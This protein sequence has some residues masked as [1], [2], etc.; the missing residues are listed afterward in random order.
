MNANGNGRDDTVTFGK[1]ADGEYITLTLPEGV[2]APSES[3]IY[4]NASGANCIFVKSYDSAGK[5]IYRLRPVETVG[6]EF[7][8]KVSLSLDR[9][10]VMNVYIPAE[11]LLEFTFNGTTYTNLNELELE[12]TVIDDKIYYVFR[13]SIPAAETAK[14][15]QLVATVASGDVTAT[16]TFN[17]TVAKYASK[18]LG[19][20]NENEKQLAKDILAYVK[21]AYVYFAASNDAEEIARVVALVDSLIGSDY[22]AKPTIEGNATAEVTGLKSATFV[23]DG[24]PSMRFYLEDGADAS[25]YEF[26]INGRKVKTTVSEDGTYVDIDVYAYLLCETVSYTIDGEEAGT[27]HI[28]A[29]YT[30][31]NGNAYTADDKAELV[32]LTECFWNYLQSARAY[33]ASVTAN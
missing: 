32:A 6:I 10:L 16:A 18:V 8:P 9:N 24:E 12:T 14:N 7:T 2:A 23:L 33:K 19:S 22:D 17:F 3:D 4:T 28:N 26:Y 25:K 13:V 29:Y 27:Y 20:S 31:V 11:I 1:N 5:T 30:Y 15:V 21:A